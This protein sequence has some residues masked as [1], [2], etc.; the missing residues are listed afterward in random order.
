MVFVVTLLRNG[1]TYFHEI[2][3]VYRIGL[4]IGRHLFFVP[5][6]VKVSPPLNFIFNF[7]AKQRLRS[8]SFL[9]YRN[10]MGYSKDS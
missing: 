9:I 4:R 6:K 1:L 8:A 3:C 7:T 10:M 2:W 5:L